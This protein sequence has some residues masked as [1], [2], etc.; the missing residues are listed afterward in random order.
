MSAGV[1]LIASTVFSAIGQISQANAASAEAK[2]NAK[3]AQYNAGIADENAKRELEASAL[4]ESM[5][6][7][8]LRRTLGSANV[9]RAKSGITA[10]GSSIFVQED[11]MIQGELDALMIR[12][13][14][15]LAHNNYKSQAAV[16]RTQAGAYKTQAKNIQTA[17]MIG[18]AGTILGGASAY[19]SSPTAA[20]SPGA[21]LGGGR[22]IPI[23]YSGYSNPIKVG[24]Y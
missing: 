14:G 19:K 15:E 16:Y 1:L 3:I 4:E 21:G 24:Q 9:A 13:K 6:R 23:D 18:V 11:S 22:S 5:Q 7:D 10:T 12:N 2:Q 20:A 17:G 8:R